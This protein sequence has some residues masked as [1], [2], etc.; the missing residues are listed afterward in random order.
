MSKI[1]WK[2]D[3][4]DSKSWGW[5]KYTSSSELMWC[6]QKCRKSGAMS[7]SYRVWK[8]RN[9]DLVFVSVSTGVC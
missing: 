4:R 6:S 8:I 7:P 9:T 2:I 3:F 1:L 5:W